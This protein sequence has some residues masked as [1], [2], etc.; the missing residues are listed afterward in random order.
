MKPQRWTRR[1]A[2]A[3]RHR[4][5]RLAWL[6]SLMAVFFGVLFLVLLLLNSTDPRVDTYDYW[7]ASAIMTIVFP[8]VGALII[9]RYPANALGWVLCA[10]GFFTGAGD[11]ATEYATYTLITEPGSLPGGVAAAWV[12]SFASDV[13]F[14]SL[15]LVPLLF[16]D[17]RPSS[18]RWRPVVWL[19]A[20]AIV[21]AGLSAA[22]MPG[23]LEH[24]PP[25][26][27]PLGIEGLANILQPLIEGVLFLFSVSLFAGIAS[28]IVRYRRSR[29]IER[30]QLKWFTYAVAMGP[31]S[32]LGNTLF[33]DLSWLIGGVGVALIPLA[34][35]IAVLKYHLYD[36][37][38]VINRT[39]VYGALTAGIAALYVLV[40]G[41]IGALLQVQDNLLISILAAGLVAVLFQPLR[42]RLQRTV[43]QL[44]YGERDDPYRVLSLLSQRLRATLSPET[45]LPTIVETVAGTLKL[46]YVA[47]ALKQDDGH[48]KFVAEYGCPTTSEPVVLP[49]SYADEAIGQLVL[50]PRA[51]GES[52]GPTDWR[53]LN[54]LAHHAETAV[55]TV[56]LTND[57]Q[58]SRER[59]VNV[60][61]EERRRLRRDLHDGLGPQLATMTLKLDAARN[62]LASH[63]S[64][65]D[66]LLVELKA[67]THAAIADIRRLVY[68]LRPPSLDELG[69]IPAIRGQATNYS[70]NGLN[71]S[72]EASEPLPPLPAA[73]EVAA[74]RIAQ[75][76]L[77][78]VVRHA[79]AH[80]CCIRLSLG[81]EL[82]LEITDD[83]VGL[84]VNP[85]AGVGLTSMRERAAELGGRCSAES[86]HTGGTRVLARLP[87]PMA[88]EQP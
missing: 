29:G 17:G 53:L 79:C 49:L 4:A 2:R 32:L 1:A 86:L 75:E 40:V 59:L 28:L 52:F 54:D 6:I 62:M 80:R 65:A 7:L 55:H 3:P 15:A 27:N 14:I 66:A 58:R 69:L 46:P 38:F 71:V 16:P 21:V 68:D 20:G 64:T 31:V 25:I 56:R 78:N 51:P 48:L 39:L 37:D 77:T 76:A 88:K 50:S 22:I 61:E 35:G 57:L 26:K 44:M 60:R 72:V 84:P 42:D 19:L 82:Q 45:V 81:D 36:I 10:I 12:S 47:I 70:Q 67:Q 85:R 74:Y 24:F 87:L 33:P 23:V 83:G 63:P 8:V 73:I 41:G 30:Q 34:I 5:V 43:N 9:S 18:R 11:F 13:G